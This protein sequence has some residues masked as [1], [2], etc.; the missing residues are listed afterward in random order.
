[1]MRQTG[2]PTL[3]SR[4]YRATWDWQGNRASTMDRSVMSGWPMFQVPDLS[5]DEPYLLACGE[6]GPY[7]SDRKYREFRAEISAMAALNPSYVMP[8]AYMEWV[9]KV[10]A[11]RQTV[12]EHLQFWDLD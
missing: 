5:P 4:R 3:P 2:S 6:P 7:A 9:E 12:P 11:W 10:L 1:M 8:V